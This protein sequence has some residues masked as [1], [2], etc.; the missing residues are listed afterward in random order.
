MNDMQM[1]EQRFI[2]RESEMKNNKRLKKFGIGS[3]KL[4]LK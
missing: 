1:S 2:K 3:K 4:L